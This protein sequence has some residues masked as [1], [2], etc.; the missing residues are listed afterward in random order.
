MNISEVF[1]LTSSEYSQ[2]LTEERALSSFSCR[3]AQ[4]MFWTCTVRRPSWTGRFWP[5]CDMPAGLRLLCN[6]WVRG[7]ANSNKLDSY[8]IVRTASMT[9][10]I[11]QPWSQLRLRLTDVLLGM[12]S[13]K[14]L[15]FGFR[16]WDLGFRVSGWVVGI[17]CCESFPGRAAAD[18]LQKGVGLGL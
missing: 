18:R 11:H 13:A 14:A 4:G 5:H 15:S 6:F 2:L 16:V 1:L 3:R 12:T 17:G 8:L 9:L 10:R 7:L